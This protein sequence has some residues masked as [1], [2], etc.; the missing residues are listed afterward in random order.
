M[1]IT[2][3]LEININN[4]TKNYYELLGYVTTGVTD[5]IDIK[6][7]PKNIQRIIECSC[8]DCGKY[9]KINYQ[10]YNM[11]LEKKNKKTMIWC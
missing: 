1:L 3:K 10:N 4:R 8:D 5:L 9:M 6:D 7:I 2:S 11:G